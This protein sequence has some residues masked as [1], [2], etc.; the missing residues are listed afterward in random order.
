MNLFPFDHNML[1]ETFGNLGVTYYM[2]L[3]GLEMDLSNL[4]NTGKKSWSIAI[5]G[6]LIPFCAGGLLYFVPML[7][8]IKRKPS[9]VGA[10]FW[11]ITLTITSFPDLARTLSDVKLLHTELGRTALTSAIITDICTWVLLAMAITL[12]GESRQS[13]IFTTIPLISFGLFCYFALRP[14]IVWMI[15]RTKNKQG[16]VNDRQVYFI[17][18]GVLLCGLMT[19]ACGSHSLVGG[20]LFG[21]IIPKGELA[22]EIM[23]RTEEAVTG[24][25]LPT[26]VITSGLRTNFLYLILKTKWPY[27]LMIA[28]IASTAKFVSTVFVSSIF[29]MP[30]KEGL[31]LGFLM[32]S[33]GVFALIVLNEGRNIRVYF[34]Y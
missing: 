29:G 12:L 28:I 8:D 14:A 11:A 19:D 33:K 27:V 4:K 34:F 17:L 5:A 24:I 32:N 13:I 21:L 31:I 18:T 7:K 1:L 10:V 23:E 30:L 26:F 16:R 9:P 6:I 3:V 25:M 20:F 15:Q 22:I 2:F